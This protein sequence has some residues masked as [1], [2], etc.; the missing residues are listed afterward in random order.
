[1]L[2]AR[3]EICDKTAS[4]QNRTA[5]TGCIKPELA[6]RFVVGGCVGRLGPRFRCTPQWLLSALRCDVPA[7]ERGDVDARGWIIA[8]CHLRD[9]SWFQSPDIRVLTNYLDL[10]MAEDY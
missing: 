3:V 5:G 10:R 6:R 8:R 2:P 4:L 1:V 7:R 9:P